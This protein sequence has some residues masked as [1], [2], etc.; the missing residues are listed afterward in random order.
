MPSYLCAN[1]VN[2]REKKRESVDIEN[3]NYIQQI[4]KKFGLEK[5]CQYKNKVDRSDVDISGVHCILLILT[6]K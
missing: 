6:L 2:V 4:G 5:A 1:N 3:F